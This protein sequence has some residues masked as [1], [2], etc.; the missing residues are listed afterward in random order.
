MD[1][2]AP[3]FRAESGEWGDC[4]YDE[5]EGTSS[6]INF[7]YADPECTTCR[8]RFDVEVSDGGEYEV[9]KNFPTRGEVE[10]ALRPTA[11][12]LDLLEL[13]YYWGASYTIAAA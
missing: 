8:A 2:T 10:A 3:G 5:C 13:E 4:Y 11:S 6:S 12:G 1:N 9:L 7:R